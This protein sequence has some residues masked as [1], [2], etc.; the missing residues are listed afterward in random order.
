[1]TFYDY[2][3]DRLSVFTREEASAIVA[4]L[5]FKRDFDSEV[6]D[7]TGL[8]AALNVFWLERAQTGPVAASLKHHVAEQDAYLAAIRAESEASHGAL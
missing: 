1:M 5:T 3:G 8:E 2:A 4:Y 6:D 7:K